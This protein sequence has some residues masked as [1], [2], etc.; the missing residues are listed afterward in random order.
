MISVPGE[1]HNKYKLQQLLEVEL[2][3]SCIHLRDQ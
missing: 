1:K 3:A 2:S